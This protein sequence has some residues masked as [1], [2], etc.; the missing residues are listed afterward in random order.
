MVTGGGFLPFNHFRSIKSWFQLY[1]ISRYFQTIVVV[2]E[3]LPTFLTHDQPPG[4]IET[5][6]HLFTATPKGKMPTRAQSFYLGIVTKRVLSV[7][8]KW[9]ET[10]TTSQK[11]HT[12]LPRTALSN[13][14]T[15]LDLP[16]K[17]ARP[18]HHP[19]AGLFGSS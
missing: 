10:K 8:P 9:L 19:K 12:L 3:S 14:R 1:C 11:Y 18:H 15:V 5:F 17:K 6:R 4:K 16:A 7:T 13:S 2:K